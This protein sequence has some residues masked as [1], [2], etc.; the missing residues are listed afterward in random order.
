[1]GSRPPSPSLPPKGY[2]NA[3]FDR[4]I[5]DES[6]DW[7]SAF[8][9][10]GRPIT[11]SEFILL[12]P[13]VV[14]DTVETYFDSHVDLIQ[15][16]LQKQLQKHSDRLK[17]KAE[18]F[19]IKDLSGDLLA[20]NFEREIKN[21]KLK[22]RYKLAI[23]PLKNFNLVNLKDFHPYGLLGCIMAVCK[24]RPHTREGFILLRCHDPPLLRFDVWN[25]SRVRTNIGTR[26]F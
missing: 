9:L 19:K 10:L 6:S 7:S 22:V 4:F 16:K 11:T 25:A 24:G 8:T 2:F 23:S 18:E 13:S 12:S 17:L 14:Q 1:M 20:E 15:R 5:R 21:F 26:N 3:P